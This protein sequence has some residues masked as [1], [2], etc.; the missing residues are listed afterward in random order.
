M[1][2]SHE[3]ARERVSGG[4]TQRGNRPSWA[5]RLLGVGLGGGIVL[6]SVAVFAYLAATR[7]A[8]PKAMR[9]TSADRVM[10][11]TVVR[12]R[13]PRQWTGYGTA[14][15]LACAD[16]PA[17]VTATVEAIGPGI[18]RGTPIAQGELIVRLDAADFKAEAEIA[19]DSIKS[20]L[21]ERAA[22]DVERAALAER[23]VLAAQ[24][25]E[26]ARADEARVV[27]AALEAGATQREV[28]RAR[29][30]R[31]VAERASLLL[32]ESIA[33]CGPR[34]DS[35]AARR[36]SQEAAL[37]RA[38][39][40]VARCTITS[41]ITGT[42]AAFDL[43]VGESVGAGS[44]VARVVDASRVE[45]PI[46]L[47]AA[48]RGFVAVGDAVSLI[49]AGKTVARSSV[50][51]IGPEDDPA[52]RTMM[53]FVEIDRDR[54]GPQSPAPGAFVEA[55]VESQAAELRCV[56]PRRSVRNERVLVLDGD[57]L[58]PL[59]V[60]VGHSFTGELPASGVDDREWLVLAEPV[61]EGTV[62]A[63]DAARV[64]R[65]GR[66]VEGTSKP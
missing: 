64:L 53:V 1:A 30:Q 22:L 50:A 35:L 8:P 25:L 3:P 32:A 16:V 5:R 52:D 15:A 65:P 37:R 18:A 17:R 61:A 47:S 62:I 34:E 4:T 11:M 7:P 41:P 40:A 27:S 57:Q 60:R 44:S 49:A 33:Q 45:V 13:V 31:I 54:H 10:V 46:A 59:A 38:E 39:D 42:L 19:A 58:R 63:L 23:H 2:D 12:A 29:A 66:R 9:D 43:K 36:T 51:R 24:E 26:L 20:I 28:D 6:F 21:A 56:V 55:V 14:A 48:A